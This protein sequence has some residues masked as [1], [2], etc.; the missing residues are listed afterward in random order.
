MRGRTVSPCSEVAH[1]DRRTMTGPNTTTCCR[2]WCITQCRRRRVGAVVK[3]LEI[4]RETRP[5][6][7]T[8]WYTV[9]VTNLRWRFR[10]CLILQWFQRIRGHRWRVHSLRHESQASLR[11]Y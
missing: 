1:P 3:R 6:R 7:P 11:K 10:E 2:N 8:W 4:V 9:V 5:F